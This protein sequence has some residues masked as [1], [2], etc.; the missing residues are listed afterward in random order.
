[1]SNTEQ[2]TTPEATD[3]LTDVKAVIAYLAET[4]PN[5]FTLDGDAKP[6]KIG[7]FQELATKL[8]GDTKVSKTQLRQA[9]RR[10]TNSWR[11]L[12]CQ[13]AG[14]QRVDLDGNACGE[15]E[16][17]HVEHAQKTLKDS[18]EKARQARA[19]KQGKADKDTKGKRPEGRKPARPARSNSAERLKTAKIKSKPE[20][21][22][23]S[24]PLKTVSPEELKV[25]KAVLVQLGRSPAKGVIIDI[26]RDDVVVRLETGLT[27]K[28]K[29]D[30]LRV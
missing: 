22:R 15:L 26:S 25:D 28:V 6:L 18:Q 27:V 1:M 8:D 11:Y 16:A 4:Y 29:A 19:E 2:Q 10:Y 30:H 9:L 17:E 14:A 12:R 3:K 13:V 7:L 5:C 21:Q 24:K 20:A 23:N